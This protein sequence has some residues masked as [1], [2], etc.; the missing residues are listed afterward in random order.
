L[1]DKSEKKDDFCLK[2][3][4]YNNFVSENLAVMPFARS[5]NLANSDATGQIETRQTTVSLDSNNFVARTANPHSGKFR[6]RACFFA[7]HNQSGCR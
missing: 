4:I 5:E 2:I 1:Q 7:L 6:E 3:E